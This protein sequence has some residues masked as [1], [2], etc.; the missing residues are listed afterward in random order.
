MLMKPPPRNLIEVLQNRAATTPD[1]TAYAFLDEHGD[2]IERLSYHQLDERARSIAGRLQKEVLFQ[3][4]VLL[5]FPQGLAFICAY[6]GV[7]YSG[8]VP[9]IVDSLFD[10]ENKND[11]VKNIVQ[12]G[13]VK[14]T[15][16][17]TEVYDQVKAFITDVD[18]SSNHF[19]LDIGSVGGD[20]SNEWV[21]PDIAGDD[22]AYLQSTSGA[23]TAPKLVIINYDAMGHMNE[24]IKA[25]YQ[26][27]AA[28][29]SVSWL[30]HYH[31]LGLTLGILQPLY[32]GFIGYLYSHL[33]FFKNPYGWLRAISRYGA[34]ISGAP[35]FAYDLLCSQEISR[36]QIK[37][38]D[39]SSWSVAFSSAER[40]EQETM[41]RFYQR[42]N[43]CG[44]S[45]TALVSSYGLAELG[46]IASGGGIAPLSA[47]SPINTT[48]AEQFGLTTVDKVAS[49]GF[50]DPCLEM[51]IV[52]PMTLRCCDDLCL[53]EIWIKNT[54][55]AAGYWGLTDAT[56]SVFYATLADSTQGPYLRTGDYGFI[57]EGEV[58]VAGKIREDDRLAKD[59]L[60]D[61]G[62][63]CHDNR[64]N[65]R[66]ANPHFYH[67]TDEIAIIGMGGVFPK[68]DNCN[69]FWDN[70]VSER[71]LISEIPASRWNWENIYGVPDN[72]GFKTNIKWGGFVNNIDAFD[73]GFF[74]IS[75]KEAQLMDPMQRKL[76][77][78]VWQAVEDSGYRMSDLAGKKVGVFV[79]IGTFDY[80]QLMMQHQQFLHAYSSTGIVHCMA[81]NR[82]SYLFDFT[83]PSESVDTA[84]SSSLVALNR[85]V[86]SIKNNECDLAIVGGANALLSSSVYVALSNAGMLS[87]DGKCKTFDAAANGYVRGEG[88]GAV[89]LKPL[90]MA[91]SGSDY[92]YGIV[93]GI[94]ENHGGHTSSL[95]APNPFAQ[96]EVIVKAL[97]DAGVS[98]D[99]VSYIEAH[100]TA[101]QLGDPIEING[102]KEAFA[103]LS[104]SNIRNVG[105][106]PHCALGSVKT[107]IGHLEAAA[108]IAGIIKVLLAM[109]HKTIPGHLHFKEINPNISLENS[110][111]YI[112]RQT[113]PWNQLRDNQGSFIPRRAGV[114]S[115][116]FGGVNTH[117]VLEEFRN[118]SDQPLPVQ[119]AVQRGSSQFIL[120]A[121]TEEQLLVYA[122][123]YRAFLE[124]HQGDIAFHHIIYT[125]HV[126]RESYNTRLVIDTANISDLVSKLGE[127]LSSQGADN[128]QSIDGVFFNVVT[129]EV[130]DAIFNTDDGIQAD[131]IE[132]FVRESDFYNLAQLWVL[133]ADIDWGLLYQNNQKIYRRVPL[134]TYPFATTNHW[135]SLRPE[136]AIDT[137]GREEKQQS[138]FDLTWI[139]ES[140]PDNDND[141]DVTLSNV[142]NG[143][144]SGSPVQF[145]LFC[146]KNGVSE[147]VSFALKAQG[148][149]CYEIHYS[150]YY[151]EIDNFKYSINPN[152]KSEYERIFQRITKNSDNAAN[153]VINFWPLDRVSGQ[154]CVADDIEEATY[155][156][157][158]SALHLLTSFGA[159][160]VNK[161]RNY[162]W[163]V[164][165]NVQPVG[166]VDVNLQSAALWGLAKTMLLEY[167]DVF[168]SIID[169][170]PIDTFK[171]KNLL[172]EILNYDDEGEISFRGE[173]RFVPRLVPSD[174]NVCSPIGLKKDGTYLITGGLGALGLLAAKWL[175]SHQV[176]KILL[177]SRSGLSAGESD[178]ASKEKQNIIKKIQRSGTDVEI[179]SADV[180]NQAQLHDALRPYLD[181]HE[182]RGVFHAA[183]AYE[184][185]LIREM[186]YHSFELV[187]KAKIQGTWNLYEMTKKCNLDYFVLY[188]S[189]AST[190]GAATGA[191]YSAAN[192]FLD[193][194]SHYC[195]STGFPAI[196]INWGGLWKDS[197]IIPKDKELYFK[198]IGVGETT[199][200]EGMR[201][202][203]SL[204]CSDD[205][206]KVIAPIAWDIFLP[207][208]N[209]KRR[210]MLFAYIE[211]DLNK[212][213]SVSVAGNAF[214]DKLVELDKKAKSVAVQDE[215]TTILKD[216]LGIAASGCIPATKGF[217]D[218]GLDSLTSI[219]LKTKIKGRMGADISTT[220]LFDHNTLTLLTVF[221][222]QTC[223]SGDVPD[224][225]ETDAQQ[226]ND[227]DV[228]SDDLKELNQLNKNDLLELL[229]MEL[230]TALGA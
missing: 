202:M 177:L 214:R 106:Q 54:Q 180:T 70:L 115:F 52:N 142:S 19:V 150:S 149:T 227:T 74:S 211:A 161:C 109:K 121:D 139:N 2:V 90:N 128:P 10:N 63:H 96:S 78:V 49:C 53:G 34:T 226:E 41:L 215:L 12:K 88:I 209:V 170:G 185:N 73:A 134:P 207:V 181:A 116:G 84:C 110:P 217:Y 163:F 81:A 59:V 7:L 14:V 174:I 175:S 230:N 145:V 32:T 193:A 143:G 159:N 92:I 40:V 79:G 168:R 62:D 83:G 94:A 37:V 146:D 11:S 187:T 140:K 213:Q 114:S 9:I 38:L 48:V 201:I 210:N 119:R 154:Q 91:L 133:G 173:Q 97:S 36:E 105:D 4:Q 171:P 136:D 198:S 6:M 191:H 28:S 108:G 98:A 165:S 204:L 147:Q 47:C 104:T 102:L 186:E 132:N 205:R 64:E 16:T 20:W 69:D 196:S 148:V 160:D 200:E 76:L 39:L 22:L 223:F 13:N 219:D 21:I 31:Y 152:E 100:G 164:C 194:F 15:L 113:Q 169:I 153:Y 82:I 212:N 122:K 18:I 45:K 188:S 111:F 123:C 221:L 23:S 75:P 199:Q 124:R 68:S 176:K 44:L 80:L 222:V 184:D 192:Y 61:A 197:G 178:N 158:N 117:V 58:F 156:T 120:S 5:F 65:H 55:G 1:E 125:L 138:I 182:L 203:E 155:F 60:I 118:T 129:D 3:D 35:N 206:Q 87:E 33:S 95:T 137:G 131:I 50:P 141:N 127:F 42:Y 8:A 107:N 29:C 189:G 101:T 57:K 179:I 162:I 144:I 135:I 86:L 51:I 167:R 46:L 43:T 183:G 216:I 85:A 25:A 71:N 172:T 89:V 126:G 224:V 225:M 99:T 72:D 130:K 190:W 93:K 151:E 67:E 66:R 30:P 220:S 157:C 195:E 208:M 17:N 166:G 27:G 24:R 229:K 56:Q 26:T 112:A 77:Q 103:T 228:F 218:L